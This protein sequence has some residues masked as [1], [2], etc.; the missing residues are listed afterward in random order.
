MF[1]K[2]SVKLQHFVQASMSQ[3]CLYL[4]RFPVDVCGIVV[5]LQMVSEGSDTCK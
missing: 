4:S 5:V 3:N 1:E 2:L